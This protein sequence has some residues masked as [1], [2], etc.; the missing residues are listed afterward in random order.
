MTPA[1][2]TARVLRIAA[3]ISTV[4]AVYA[5]TRHPYLAVPG[6]VSA[7]VL[8]T[9]AVTCDGEDRRI[10]ARHEQVRRAA[11]LDE[12]RLAVLPVPC[13]SFWRNSDG[14]VHDPVG[15]TRPPDARAEL[16]DGCCEQWWT[17]LGAAHDTTCPTVTARSSAA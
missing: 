9:I 17:S 8:L 2:R 11:V 10:R 14:Q 6:L 12:E 7:A 3:G 13:C 16:D 1:R 4:S 5:G 15:C